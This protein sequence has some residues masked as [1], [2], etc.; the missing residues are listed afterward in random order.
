MH[1]LLQNNSSKPNRFAQSWWGKTVSLQRRQ[2]FLNEDRQRQHQNEQWLAGGRRRKKTRNSGKRVETKRGPGQKVVQ[3]KR[4]IWGQSTVSRTRR[5]ISNRNASVFK[6]NHCRDC[7]SAPRPNVRKPC[8]IYLRKGHNNKIKE[9]RATKKACVKL[10]ARDW[11]SEDKQATN[12][13]FKGAQRRPV[14][15]IAW[16]PGDHGQRGHH[17]KAVHYSDGM[18]AGHIWLCPVLPGTLSVLHGALFFTRFDGKFDDTNYNR[19]SSARTLLNRVHFL[20]EMNPASLKFEAFEKPCWD[21]RSMM[22]SHG[23]VILTQSYVISSQGLVIFSQGWVI[24][25]QG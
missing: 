15:L 18:A 6:R 2:E 12:L 21:T 22:T 7:I 13:V 24:F 20:L 9:R 23:Y 10:T 3:E 14:I 4:R 17:C 11:R 16:I 19:C 25:R 1:H 8:T 5:D